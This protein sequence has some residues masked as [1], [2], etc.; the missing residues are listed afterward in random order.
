M[1][2]DQAVEL[3]DDAVLLAVLYTQVGCGTAVYL[4]A[5]LSISGFASLGL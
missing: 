3:G 4:R 5:V 1:V 2:V